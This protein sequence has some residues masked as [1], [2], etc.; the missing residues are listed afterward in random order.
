LIEA[1]PFHFK[2]ASRFTLRDLSAQPNEAF[3]GLT[4]L[5]RDKVSQGGCEDEVAKREVGGGRHRVHPQVVVISVY[6]QVRITLVCLCF[7]FLS[8]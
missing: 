6:G 2:N 8:F 5:G 4:H 1:R 7:Y 3:H